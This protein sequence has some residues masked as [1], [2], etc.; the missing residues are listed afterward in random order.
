MLKG[1]NKWFFP[2]EASI[3]SKNISLALSDVWLAGH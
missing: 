1:E 2:A 3:K